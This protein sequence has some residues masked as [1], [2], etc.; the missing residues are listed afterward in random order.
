MHVFTF[1]LKHIDK[2]D[3]GLV[4][5]LRIDG[6]KV[7]LVVRLNICLSAIKSYCYN[8]IYLGIEAKVFKVLFNI[9]ADRTSLNSGLNMYCRCL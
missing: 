7:D 6:I 8:A 2:I 4:P 3:I 5:S 1:R 9:E